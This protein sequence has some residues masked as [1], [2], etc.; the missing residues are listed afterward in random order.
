MKSTIKQSDVVR[1][2]MLVAVFYGAVIVMMETY[3]QQDLLTFLSHEFQWMFGGVSCFEYAGA[4]LG[5]RTRAR[6]GE[7]KKNQ[8]C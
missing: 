6:I 2:M 1:I 4:I 5:G 7:L 8:H 3:W